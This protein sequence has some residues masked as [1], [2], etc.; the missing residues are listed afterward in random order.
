MWLKTDKKINRVRRVKKPL[1]I[2]NEVFIYFNEKNLSSVATPPKL[3]LDK[4]DYSIWFKPAGVFAQ[5]SKWE[6]HCTLTRTG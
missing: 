4:Q 3:L 2:G 1:K 5:G 6:D